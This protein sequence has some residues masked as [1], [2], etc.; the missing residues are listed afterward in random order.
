MES[1]RSCSR[2]DDDGSALRARLGIATEAPVVAFVATLDRAHHFKRLD[3]ALE[4]IAR[5]GED[6]ETAGP[7]PHLV[8]AGGG[9]LLEG[10]RRQAAGA[11]IGER[12]HFLGAVPHAELPE[13][14]RGADLLLLTTEPPESFGIVLIEAM[15]CGLP[16]IA[17]DYPGVRA[18]VD[19]GETGLLVPPGDA[20]AVADGDP[21]SWSRA[22]AG[23]PRHDGRGRAQQVRAAV[24]LAAAARPHGGGV[25]RGDRSPPGEVRVNLLLVAYFYPPCRDTGA[26]RPAAMAKWLRRQG[27]RVT[28]LTTSAYGSDGDEED[29]VVRTRDLQRL[30]ARLHGHDRVDALFDSDTYSG[31]PHPLSQGARARAADRRLGAVRALA[32]AAAQPP[33]PASTA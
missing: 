10:F 33:R 5:V 17:T 31:R 25:R 16:T 24:E 22:G 26:H 28:V 7:A 27:H 30:R 29:G 4:A 14:L 9:E 12:V 2:P 32:G 1:T 8:V 13:V 11:G 15:A 23:G 19:D 3:L 20:D 18:V 21:A 6:D